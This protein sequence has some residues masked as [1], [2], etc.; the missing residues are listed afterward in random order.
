MAHDAAKLSRLAVIA[1]VSSRRTRGDPRAERTAP[2][3]MCVP[4]QRD[5][6]AP[7]PVDL[8]RAAFVG[9]RRNESI[10]FRCLPC[11]V[12]TWG[13]SSLCTHRVI[14]LTQLSKVSAPSRADAGGP[15]ACANWVS[16]L[17]P[18]KAA[19]MA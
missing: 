14:S 1:Q 9:A 16:R 13:L 6:Q 8:D 10:T 15:S 19:D 7:L 11:I 3:A 17:Q 2:T 12:C 5:I 18:V 4:L